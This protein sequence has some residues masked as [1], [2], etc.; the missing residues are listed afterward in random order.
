MV[1]RSSTPITENPGMARNST[2]PER[3][4]ISPV[5]SQAK[6]PRQSSG[7]SKSAAY[8]AH[9]F[10]SCDDSWCDRFFESLTS[11]H[12]QTGF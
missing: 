5:S 7:A 2:I 4:L 3:L 12:F 6:L 10:P 8:P 1:R 9:S 11:A